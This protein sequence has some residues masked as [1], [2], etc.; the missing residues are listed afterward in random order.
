MLEINENGPED[1]KINLNE[2]D[3][4]IENSL[5]L[6]QNRKIERQAYEANV[7]SDINMFEMK[8]KDIIKK[9]WESLFIKP[10]SIYVYRIK[11]YFL[12]YNYSK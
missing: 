10:K 9:Y 11:H 7:L 2:F 8:T 1:F 6:R 5:Q 3:L 4:N 12:Y